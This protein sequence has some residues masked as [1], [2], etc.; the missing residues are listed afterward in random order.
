MAASVLT[1]PSRIARLHG[2][3]KM[4][5]ACTRIHTSSILTLTAEVVQQLLFVFAHAEPV[6]VPFRKVHLVCGFGKKTFDQLDFESLIKVVLLTLVELIVEALVV[7]RASCLCRHGALSVDLVV[8][9][10][11]KYG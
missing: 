11:I 9:I 10:I 3:C 5:S 7:S 1:H 4:H 2:R 8:F 6:V